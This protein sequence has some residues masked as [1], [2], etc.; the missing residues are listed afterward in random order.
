MIRIGQTYTVI[1]KD[2]HE[3]TGMVGTIDTVTVQL[4]PAIGAVVEIPMVNIRHFVFNGFDDTYIFAVIDP[5]DDDDDDGD[6]DD[7]P[8]MPMPSDDGQRM[9]RK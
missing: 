9:D 5:D 6:P 1:H 7:E 2:G 8:L 4:M 3:D